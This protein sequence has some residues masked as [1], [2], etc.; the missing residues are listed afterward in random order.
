[1]RIKLDEQQLGWTAV[2]RARQAAEA[3][4]QPLLVAEAAR[5]LAVLTRKADWHQQAL[6]IAPTAAEHHSPEETPARPAV[7]SLVYGLPVSG[8]T[9][10]EPRGLAARAGALA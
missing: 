1:M 2:D 6:S 10:T 4:G 3:A 5:Q 7:K 8:R 9:T